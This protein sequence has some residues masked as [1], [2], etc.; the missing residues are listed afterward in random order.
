MNAVIQAMLDRRSVRKYKNDPVP[1]EMLDT[2]IRAGLYAAS[3]MG[4]Q[5][6]LIVAITDPGMIKKLSEVNCRI[7]GWDEKFDPFYGAPAVLIVL[8]KKGLPTAVEDGSLV[9]A[10]LLLAASSLG[11]GSCWIHRAREE[12]EMPEWQDFLRK[13]GVT[14][15]YIGIGHCIVGYAAEKPKAAPRKDGRVIYVEKKRKES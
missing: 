12:F 3:G 7:G 11:L 2:I 10:N 13:H 4:R 8:A 15:E 6:T 14:D 5:Q 1:R 9:L